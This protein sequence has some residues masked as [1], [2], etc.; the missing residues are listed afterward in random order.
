MLKEINTN[1]LSNDNSSRS[2]RK[3]INYAIDKI[4]KRSLFDVELSNQKV[5]S[6]N[7]PAPKRIASG[8]LNEFS[9]VHMELERGRC[10]EKSIVNQQKR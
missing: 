6:K 10:L 3:R 7:L 5:N 8:W 2:M 1:Y 4:G 9:V